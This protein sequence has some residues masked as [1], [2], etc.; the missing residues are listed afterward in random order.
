MSKFI[1]AL[2]TEAEWF[3]SVFNFPLHFPRIG[4]GSRP[5]FHFPSNPFSLNVSSINPTA[6]TLLL[7]KVALKTLPSS[8]PVRVLLLYVPVIVPFFTSV[9]VTDTFSSATW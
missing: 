8:V 7:W 6:L 1:W 3:E 4:P 9:K 2:E 5:F